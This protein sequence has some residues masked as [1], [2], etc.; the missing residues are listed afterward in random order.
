MSSTYTHS[1]NNCGNNINDNHIDNNGCTDTKQK[2]YLKGNTIISG[3]ITFESG[4]GEII[5]QNSSAKI[6]GK[7]IGGTIVEKNL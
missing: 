7:V 1:N 2:L 5:I 6:L 3:D 4:I